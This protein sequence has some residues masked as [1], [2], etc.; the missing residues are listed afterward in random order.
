MGG[1]RAIAVVLLVAAGTPAL[2]DQT[3]VRVF[4]Q[5]TPPM[6]APLPPTAAARAAERPRVRAEG[7]ELS[8]Q[9]TGFE[10]LFRLATRLLP[11]S[12]GR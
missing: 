5:L 12:A 8:P 6:N 1:V 11:S 10:S 7:P 3:E 4:A 9:A 2:A